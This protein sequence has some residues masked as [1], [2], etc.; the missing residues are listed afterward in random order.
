[1]PT[2][3]ISAGLGTRVHPS[4]PKLQRIAAGKRQPDY[5]WNFP[6]PPSLTL[7]RRENASVLEN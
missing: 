2:S 7:L 3:W 1:M 5:H 6:A 4:L